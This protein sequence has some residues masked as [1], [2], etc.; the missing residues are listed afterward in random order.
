MDVSNDDMKSVSQLIDYLFEGS[1]DSSDVQEGLTEF[2]EQIQAQKEIEVKKGP[3]KTALSSIGVDVADDKL[4]P[5]FASVVV[6]FDNASDYQNAVNS[7]ES[8]E[9]MELLASSGW[10]MVPSGDSDPE[11]PDY[12]VRFIEIDLKD[13][14]PSDSDEPVDL[15]KLMKD[16]NDFFSTNPDDPKRKEQAKNKEK[17]PTLEKESIEAIEAASKMLAKLIGED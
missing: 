6:H 15:E 9:G 14:A 16:V 13:E 2:V 1:K 8:P 4:V 17:I 5:E 3:L 11:A 12:R 7:L 10:V